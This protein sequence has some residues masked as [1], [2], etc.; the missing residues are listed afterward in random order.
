M[1]R[2]ATCDFVPVSSS[3]I[4]KH[5]VQLNVWKICSFQKRAPYQRGGCP[6]T[7]DTPPLDPPLTKTQQLQEQDQD[8][9]ASR[10]IPRP[11]LSSFK[12]KTKTQQ[13]QDQYQD[14]DSVSSRPRPRL[15]SFR[16]NTKTKTQQLQ[17]QDQD[18]AASGPRLSS[19]GT[20]T[21]TKTQQ[22]QDQ[23]QDSAAS[24][25]RPRLSNLSAVV[26]ICTSRR[27]KSICLLNV[28]IK[29]GILINTH[30]TKQATS[31][32]VT[33]NWVPFIT[34]YCVFS[35]VMTKRPY[36]QH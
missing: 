30:K 8:S 4:E 12:T 27:V 17:D 24:G 6:D 7:L 19:F 33:Y 3:R 15:S 25:P 5:P 14:Q 31:C 28:V 18:S 36:T 13:L 23:D 2:L 20:K 34:R 29:Q 11:R 22:L 26:I 16:T 35:Q 32:R 1:R 9:A 21:K 10:P